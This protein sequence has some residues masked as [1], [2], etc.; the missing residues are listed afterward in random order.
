MDRQNHDAVHCEAIIIGT[1]RVRN[2]TITRLLQVFTGIHHRH[3]LTHRVRATVDS[4]ILQ[5]FAII[6]NVLP[7]GSVTDLSRHIRS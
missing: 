3:G 1:A 2:D 7:P 6:L 5:E 4:V